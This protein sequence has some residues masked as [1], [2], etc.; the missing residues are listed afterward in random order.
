MAKM[1]EKMA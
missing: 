1:N